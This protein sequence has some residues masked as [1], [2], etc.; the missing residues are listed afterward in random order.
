MPYT[1]VDI[2]Y[3]AEA[4]RIEAV[5]ETCALLPADNPCGGEVE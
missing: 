1:P 2:R 5:K 3:A 4:S